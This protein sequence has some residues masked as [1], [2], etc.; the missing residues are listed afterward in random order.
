[1]RV[2]LLRGPIMDKGNRE[3]VICEVDGKRRRINY[4][5]YLV[6]KA[7]IPVKKHDEV[8]HKDEDKHN[9]SLDNLKVMKEYK[10]KREHSKGKKK[11]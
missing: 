10:H 9:N 4:A 11:K 2:L 8:H 3:Y 6:L 1:M 7:G 5:K